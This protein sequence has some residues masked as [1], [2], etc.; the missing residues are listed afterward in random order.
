[1][2]VFAASVLR[3]LTVRAAS[4]SLSVV[5]MPTDFSFAAAKV[6]KPSI[7]ESGYVMVLDLKGALSELAE[8]RCACNDLAHLVRSD[9]VPAKS[10][11]FTRYILNL[12]YSQA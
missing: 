11:E 3:P 2:P 1:M 7:S 4:S 6:G 12:A 10:Q 8:P 9:L 5:R